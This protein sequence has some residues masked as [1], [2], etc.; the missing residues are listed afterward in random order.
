MRLIPGKTKVSVELFRGITLGDVFVC[1]VAMAMI[2]LVLLSN[3]SWKL[4]ICIGIAVVVGLLL[5]R[6]D[7]QPNYVY[8]LHILS[9]L[10]YRRHFGRE[11]KDKLLMEAGEGR[12]K[13]VAF[14]KVFHGKPEGDEER[15]AAKAQTRL[16]KTGKKNREKE[17]RREDKLLKSMKTPEEVK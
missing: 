17:R 2:I 14:E 16:D 7:E 5:I 11:L 3:L 1:A 8:L 10:G 4:G 9:F 6:L 15:K 13:D 12:L